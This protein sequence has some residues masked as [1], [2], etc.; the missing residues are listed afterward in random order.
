M[1]DENIAKVSLSTTGL[2]EKDKGIE[3]IEIYI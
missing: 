3:I 1:D 2:Q